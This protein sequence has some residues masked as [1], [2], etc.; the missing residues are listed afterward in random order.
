MY[1]GPEA[2]MTLSGSRS[3]KEA[4][5]LEWREQEGVGVQEVGRG[6]TMQASWATVRRFDFILKA[7]GG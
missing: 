1:K 5:G 2:G 7:M 6:E 4:G 3:R